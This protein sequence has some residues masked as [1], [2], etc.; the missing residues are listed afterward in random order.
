MTEAVK[1]A[2]AEA[3]A[4]KPVKKSAAKKAP[5]KTATKAIKIAV[6]SKEVVKVQFGGDEFDLA[7]IK[8]AVEADYKGKFKGKVKTV[9]IYF[10]PE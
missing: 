2:V 10:K 6:T 4:E 1:E 5:A 8:K 7:E 9:E 3:P